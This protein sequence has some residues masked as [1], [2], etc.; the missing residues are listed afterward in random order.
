LNKNIKEKH[1]HGHPDGLSDHLL[2]KSVFD[3]DKLS[4]I[5]KLTQIGTALSSEKN[6]ERLLEII[7]DGACDFTKAQGGTLYIMSDRKSVV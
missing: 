3:S 5:K 7:V 2:S 1:G 4:F 6:L